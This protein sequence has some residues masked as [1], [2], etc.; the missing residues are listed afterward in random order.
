[1]FCTKSPR[2][3]TR[4]TSCKPLLYFPYF[5]QEE[6]VFEDFAVQLQLQLPY[7][8]FYFQAADNGE[9]LNNFKTDL[10]HFEI[11]GDTQSHFVAGFQTGR[12][13]AGNQTNNGVIFGPGEKYELSSNWKSWSIPISEL[14]E[15]D[16]N[17]DLT[18][19][20][21]AFFLKGEKEFDGKGIQI[22]NVTYT[23]E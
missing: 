10:L 14:V 20:T 7:C 18:N 12:Y 17:A 1:M 4:S 16:K 23:L 13:A 22:R 5:A 2:L 8:E 6:K 15:V 3:W 9:N 11:T 21:S 19:V